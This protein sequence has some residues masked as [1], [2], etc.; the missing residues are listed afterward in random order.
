M[1]LDVPSKLR[2]INSKTTVCSNSKQSTVTATRKS[3]VL[4]WQ[5]GP[6]GVEWRTAISCDVEWGS[7]KAE[8]WGWWSSGGATAALWGLAVLAVCIGC[9]GCM[10]LFVGLLLCKRTQCTTLLFAIGN[11]GHI[12]WYADEIAATQ[13]FLASTHSTPWTCWCNLF[14]GM[15]LVQMGKRALGAP[16]SVPLGVLWIHWMSVLENPWPSGSLK[17]RDDAFGLWTLYP[18]VV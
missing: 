11:S 4:E 1:F 17:C 18:T 16:L 13:I 2:C 14:Y 8:L 9:I 5:V 3:E 15:L 6:T 12:L 10:S 7:W